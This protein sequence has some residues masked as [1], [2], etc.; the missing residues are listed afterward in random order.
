MI[1]CGVLGSCGFASMSCRHF[2]ARP[3]TFRAI[4]CKKSLGIV[5]QNLLG[6]ENMRKFAIHALAASVLMTSVAPAFAGYWYEGTYYCVWG[7][8]HDALGNVFYACN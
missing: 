6:L 4:V 5:F 1:V 8:Y 3:N 7:Y 2:R